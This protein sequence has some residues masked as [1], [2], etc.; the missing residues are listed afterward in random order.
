MWCCTHLCGILNP[1]KTATTQSV[2]ITQKVQSTTMVSNTYILNLKSLFTLTHTVSVLRY[3]SQMQEIIWNKSDHSLPKP[4][5]F[6]FHILCFI[7]EDQYFAFFLSQLSNVCSCKLL[8]EL[9]KKSKSLQSA[10]HYYYFLNQPLENGVMGKREL[11]CRKKYQDG[12][13]DC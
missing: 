6:S 7:R 9:T 13:Q 4:T 3:F 5:Q 10:F 12:N 11:K 2:Q 8:S 1:Q